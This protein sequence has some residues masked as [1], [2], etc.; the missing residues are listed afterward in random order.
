MLNWPSWIGKHGYRDE[1]S[2]PAANRRKLSRLHGT[3]IAEG[4][5][6]QNTGSIRPGSYRVTGAGLRALKRVGEV[7][8]EHI[9][10]YREN[11]AM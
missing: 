10:G 6:E 11:V 1:A 5:L 2:Y 8:I 4:W 7:T 9:P 3:L